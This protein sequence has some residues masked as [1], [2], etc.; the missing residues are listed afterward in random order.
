MYSTLRNRFGIP[1]VISVI[2]LVFAL[3]GGAFAANDLGDSGKSATASAKKS[4]KGPRGPRGP[5][6]ATGPAGPAG[7]AGPAG[8]AGAK[9]D[10]G[11]PGAA[12][13]NGA[14]GAKGKDGTGVTSA[15]FEGTNEPLGEPCAEAGGVEFKSTSPTT[16]ACNGEDGANGSPWTVGTLPP[17][18][19]QTGTYA[20]FS[21]NPSEESVA[22]TSISF[23]VPLANPLDA[24]HAVYASLE[25]G[26]PDPVHCD[27]TTAQPKAASGYL[28]VYE[29]VAFA[30][31]IFAINPASS[32]GG[33]PVAPGVKGAGVTGAVLRFKTNGKL[34]AE[35][36]TPLRAYGTFAVTG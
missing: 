23:A 28:C 24:S 26:N 25:G 4:A 5:K 7:A 21:D 16:Y 27:G 33:T 6:G 8:P 3:V 35:E 14:A 30:S 13:N 17:G 31:E 36:F 22:F 12:G 20:Y 32:V 11:A 10:A 2:A 18:A 29:K 19:T 15:S 34:A 9:G 1:G